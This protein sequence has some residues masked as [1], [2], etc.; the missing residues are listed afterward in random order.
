[1]DLLGELSGGAGVDVGGV[2][3][4][5]E[6]RDYVIGHPRIVAERPEIV[7]IPGVSCR[8]SVVV[9]SARAHCRGCG[10]STELA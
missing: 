4:W 1:V 2:L 9:V 7:Q 10:L 8:R 5:F 6:A 3:V